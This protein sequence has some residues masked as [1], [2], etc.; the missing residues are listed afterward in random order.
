VHVT[1]PTPSVSTRPTIGVVLSSS[2]VPCKVADE[3]RSTV[4]P[5]YAVVVSSLVIAKGTWLL[6]AR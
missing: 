4:G 1:P 3:P 5:V 2:S 6:L